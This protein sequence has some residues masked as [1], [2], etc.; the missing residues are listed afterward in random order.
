[1]GFAMLICVQ[2]FHQVPRAQPEGVNMPRAL[3][4]IDPGS[5]FTCTDRYR[6]HCDDEID[7]THSA[8]KAENPVVGEEIIVM[9]L[10]AIT[11]L[12]AKGH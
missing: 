6:P 4:A 5:L 11:A 2:R 12:T 9:R 8:K 1:M 7:V 3:S 10:S